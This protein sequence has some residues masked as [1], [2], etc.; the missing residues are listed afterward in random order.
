[1]SAPTVRPMDVLRDAADV[2]L[3]RTH[4]THAAGSGSYVAG[5]LQHEATLGPDDCSDL[6]IAIANVIMI[7]PS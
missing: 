5:W 4:D 2:V 1:M 6:S 7:D 3:I